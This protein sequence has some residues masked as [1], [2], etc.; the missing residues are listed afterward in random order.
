MVRK[1][2]GLAIKAIAT[3]LGRLLADDTIDFVKLR[4]DRMK[5]HIS[6]EFEK[7]RTEARL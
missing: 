1:K 3:L 6:Q 5:T 7:K 4:P 2:R